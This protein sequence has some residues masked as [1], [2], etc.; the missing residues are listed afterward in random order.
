MKTL[1]VKICTAWIGKRKKVESSVHELLS[2]IE[3]NTGSFR[4]YYSTLVVRSYILYIL[5][6]FRLGELFRWTKLTVW[7]RENVQ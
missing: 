4:S 2:L 3:H 5:F 7:R 6:A 1:A